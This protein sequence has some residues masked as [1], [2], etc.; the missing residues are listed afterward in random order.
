[1]CRVH[2]FDVGG[3]CLI[4]IEDILSK[5]LFYEVIM[6]SSLHLYGNYA[7]L[8]SFVGYKLTFEACMHIQF[9]PEHVVK[10]QLAKHVSL[11]IITLCIAK[12]VLALFSEQ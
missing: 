5:I 2:S 4:N 6:L 7:F 8:L 3:K 10:H 9:L 11:N 12:S 1:M